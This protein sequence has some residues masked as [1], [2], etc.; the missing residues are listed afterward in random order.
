MLPRSYIHIEAIDRP[1]ALY[2]VYTTV[3]AQQ[4]N[5]L[6]ENTSQNDVFL[7]KAYICGNSFTLQC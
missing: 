4:T 5:L 7:P 3:S 6:P 2:I 1:T